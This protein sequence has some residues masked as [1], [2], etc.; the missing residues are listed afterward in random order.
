MTRELITTWNDYRTAFDRLLAEAQGKI[1]FYD[2]DLSKPGFASPDRLDHLQRILRSGYDLALR[3]AVRHAASL[4]QREPGLMKLLGTY[5]HRA[6]AQ[7]TPP[8]L[9]HLRDS[10]FIV[11][12]RHALIRFDRDQPRSKLLLDEAAEIRPYLQRFEEIWAEGGESIRP[13]TLGL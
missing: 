5:S 4:P 6:A 7:E 8:Q 3:L 1:S 11:D 9:A 10:M 13:T 12:D 2:E